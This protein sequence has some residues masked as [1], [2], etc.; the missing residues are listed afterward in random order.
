MPK[1]AWCNWKLFG[2]MVILILIALTTGCDR[3]TQEHGVEAEIEVNSVVRHMVYFKDT[4]TNIC[5]AYLMG[6]PGTDGNAL[7][8]VPCE[9][10]PPALLITVTP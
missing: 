2:A 5:F 7:A 9:S 8:T 3:F 6:G 1:R 10:V 4:R